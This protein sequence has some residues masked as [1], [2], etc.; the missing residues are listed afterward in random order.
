MDGRAGVEIRKT[1]SEKGAANRRTSSAL[2]HCADGA[3]GSELI[4]CHYEA[5]AL[6]Q[7]SCCGITGVRQHFK[8][9]LA[10]APEWYWAR[11]ASNAEV[12]QAKRGSQMCIR[13]SEIHLRVQHRH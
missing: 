1:R 9:R 2:G 3:A 13:W 6:T 12:R 10:E 7:A 5:L 11:S 8:L 4:R